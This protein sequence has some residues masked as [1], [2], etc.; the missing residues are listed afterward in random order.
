[1]RIK[2]GY[3]RIEIYQLTVYT[4]REIYGLL[5]KSKIMNYFI[6]FQSKYHY[7]LTDVAVV[8]SLY[9]LDIKSILFPS[10]AIT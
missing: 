7:L 2:I 10:Q 9:R 4:I 8:F 6:L 3:Y 1:V 5:L